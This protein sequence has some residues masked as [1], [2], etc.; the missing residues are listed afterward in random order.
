[1]LESTYGTLAT[2]CGSSK[3]TSSKMAA[4]YERF[5][6]ACL[7]VFVAGLAASLMGT[8]SQS[9]RHQLLQLSSLIQG[10]RITLPWRSVGAQSTSLSSSFLRVVEFSSSPADPGS[11]ESGL[12]IILN[13]TALQQAFR[14]DWTFYLF[15]LSM[16]ETQFPKLRTCG[17]TVWAQQTY[18]GL[19]L[20]PRRTQDI[21]AASFAV[22][23]PY[24]AWET[25]W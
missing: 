7:L 6:Y 10:Y 4:V 22:L 21:A 19:L 25:N 16:L 2:Y 23:P 5:V 18:E 9:Y 3:G 15:T 20:H 17:I 24:L 13:S 14:H 1:M 12:N 11:K 8:Y